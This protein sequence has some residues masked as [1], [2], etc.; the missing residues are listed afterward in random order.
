MPLT[1]IS[2][3]VM[4]YVI[5][6]F[7]TNVE[8]AFLKATSPELC[9]RITKWIEATTG[10]YRSLLR[11]ADS[12]NNYK[13]SGRILINLEYA[14][15]KQPVRNI[16][17][18]TSE[19][20]SSMLSHIND[21]Y[22]LSYQNISHNR[23]IS[24]LY[25]I[26]VISCNNFALHNTH[27]DII[28]CLAGVYIYPYNVINRSYDRIR[29]KIKEAISCGKYASSQPVYDILKNMRTWSLEH[30]RDIPS[31]NS[32]GWLR[33]DAIL[34]LQPG[35]PIE[36]VWGI[37]GRLSHIALSIKR[38]SRT[39]KYKKN[40]PM[41]WVSN[42]KYIK[43]IRTCQIKIIDG[44]LA[45]IMGNL[46]DSDSVPIIHQYNVTTCQIFEF[47]TLVKF[48]IQHIP[49]PEYDLSGLYSI[50]QLFNLQINVHCVELNENHDK[51]IAV[52][53]DVIRH[54]VLRKWNTYVYQ[55]H[56]LFR[57]FV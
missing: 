39:P 18:N 25:L 41:V 30:V 52:A 4:S 50:I 40:P 3:D 13:I 5:F 33:L 54:C 15:I 22:P 21:N 10:R 16:P 2:S 14:R 7:L 17:I 42:S 56:P 8:W 11:V 24:F 46:S 26:N 6:T 55:T 45:T 44:I 28:K 35:V 49:A 12:H 51:A 27:L 43:M 9:D 57:I 53:I 23:E 47:Y 48:I 36:F 37:L 34:S 38:L 20:V 1:K 19:Y 31:P 32:L 29:D